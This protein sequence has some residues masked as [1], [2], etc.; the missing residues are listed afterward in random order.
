MHFPISVICVFAGGLLVFAAGCGSNGNKQASNSSTSPTGELGPFDEDAGEFTTTES[1][2][3]YR[4]TREGEGEKP[5]PTDAV[6]VHYRGMLADG[7]EF[8]STYRRRQPAGFSLGRVI[9]GWTEG[10]QL[11]KV[12][13]M[14]E[15]IV[16]PDLGYGDDGSGPIAPNSTLF[17]TIELI[18][19]PKAGE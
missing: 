4:I 19:I 10:L 18:K 13:G 11:I 5:K 9:P 14:I 7:N 6:V 1:G 2:L 12:G 8:D 17:F 3:K 16:P 15:L